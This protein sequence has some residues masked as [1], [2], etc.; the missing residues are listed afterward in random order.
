MSKTGKLNLTQCLKA[1][2]PAESSGARSKTLGCRNTSGKR[3][4]FPTPGSKLKHKARKINPTQCL[5]RPCPHR[6]LSREP[7]AKTA[8]G[9]GSW[10]ELGTKVTVE[11]R[12]TDLSPLTGQDSLIL[13]ARLVINPHPHLLMTVGSFSGW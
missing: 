6:L 1:G 12:K 13:Q 4:A 11:V 3:S 2:S 7:F 9:L 8:W 10:I 5:N